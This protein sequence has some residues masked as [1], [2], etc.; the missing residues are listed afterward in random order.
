MAGPVTD[1]KATEA[2]K[3]PHYSVAD[4]MNRIPTSPHTTLII[5]FV[6]MGWFAE[7]IDLGG[8]SFLMPTIREY[9]GMDATTGRF[10]CSMAAIIAPSYL[11]TPCSG[12]F[13]FFRVWKPRDP[14]APIPTK[15]RPIPWATR[16]NAPD[17]VVFFSP[18]GPFME[19]SAF[20][21]RKSRNPR[22]ETP[23][24]WA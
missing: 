21:C 19:K 20:A 24:Q 9:F 22:V 2:K 17:R 13:F 6:L 16:Q 18:Y 15:R 10:C 23:P 7:T 4:R 8:T 5:F 14:M 1:G 3:E 11:Q 12:G